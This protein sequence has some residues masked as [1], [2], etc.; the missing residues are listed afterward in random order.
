MY[1]HELPTALIDEYVYPELK[2]KKNVGERA[3]VF[4]QFNL[5][6]CISTRWVVFYQI[7]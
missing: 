7:I 6:S 5:R 4:K 2:K 3:L 1:V